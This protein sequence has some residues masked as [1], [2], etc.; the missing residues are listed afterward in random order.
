MDKQTYFKT[1]CKQAGCICEENVLMKDYTAFRIG[2]PADFFVKAKDTQAAAGVIRRAAELG[3]PLTIVGKGSNLLVSDDGIR[4]TVLTLEET[5]AQPV[6]ADDGVICCPA[7]AN[8]SKL[9]A[10]A[11]QNEL[12]GLEFAWGIPASV[13]GAVYM[14]AGAYGGE[15]K[16]VLLA[17]EYIDPMGNIKT[18]QTKDLQFGYRKSW[19]MKHAGC[20]ITNT[21]FKLSRGNP[22][23][24]RE[25]MTQNMNARKEKQPLD[26]PSAG[27]TFKRPP[28]AY[29]AQLIEQCGMKGYRIGGA[30]VSKK[31]AG[32]IV[33]VEDASCQDV[34]L[35]IEEVKRQVHKKSGF[36]LECEVRIL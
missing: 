10:F 22:S 2:G 12:T 16:D 8:L 33:N 4:G 32:F 17:V 23:A 7:G 30:M 26:L 31:H 1:F 19:F 6:M 21:V 11:L 29:A 34:K 28:G 14:N 9:C 24:I 5:A 35:L 18:A 27:S 15:I 13:G 20:M 36:M 25:K 3:V